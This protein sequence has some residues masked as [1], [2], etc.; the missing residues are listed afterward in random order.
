MSNSLCEKRYQI[1]SNFPITV[2]KYCRTEESGV[3]KTL[4]SQTS[5]TACSK[6]TKG[7]GILNNWI[8]ILDG[9]K[10]KYV[11]HLNF[12]SKIKDQRI[13]KHIELQDAGVNMH[14][15]PLQ[16]LHVQHVI[17]SSEV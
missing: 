12:A 2:D 6:Y 7:F 4:Q 17:L 9:I 1:L 13:F 5:I 8:N 10:G 11:L 16:I 14:V 3:K 15:V